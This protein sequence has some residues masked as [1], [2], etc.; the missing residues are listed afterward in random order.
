MTERF[1]TVDTIGYCEERHID[2]KERL[3]AES[4]PKAPE[5]C[6]SGNR[7]WHTIGEGRTW[8]APRRLGTGIRRLDRIPKSSDIA[9]RFRG[10]AQPIVMHPGKARCRSDRL[11]TTTPAGYIRPVQ[12]SS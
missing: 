7:R 5:P 2:R 6:D 10:T 4:G 8:P 3:P 1:L 9:S 12:W 11:S